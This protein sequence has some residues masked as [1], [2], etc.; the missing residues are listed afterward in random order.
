MSVLFYNLRPGDNIIFFIFSLKI[1]RVIA[2]LRTC[3]LQLRTFL[4][5]SVLTYVTLYY[6]YVK[7]WGAHVRTYICTYMHV[8]PLHVRSYRH[9]RT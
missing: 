1:S 5:F 3:T 7:T 2:H 9:L 6:N 4:K 8:H